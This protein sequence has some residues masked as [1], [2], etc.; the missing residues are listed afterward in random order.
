MI[1]AAPFFIVNVVMGLIPI[2]VSTFW[3]VSQMGM[4]AGT[5]IFIYA[6]S[7]VPNLTTLVDKGVNA[8][9]TPLQMTQ[10]ISAFALLSVFP[11]I[12]RWG[13]KI[14]KSKVAHK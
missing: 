9:F 3:W 1:P 2:E 13:I 10:I 7:S 5:A 4:L 12:A 11:L 8:A 14:W 6:G